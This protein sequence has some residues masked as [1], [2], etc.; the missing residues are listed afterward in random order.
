MIQ[1]L[2]LFEMQEVHREIRVS[3]ILSSTIFWNGTWTAHR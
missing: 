2:L 1:K 3:N